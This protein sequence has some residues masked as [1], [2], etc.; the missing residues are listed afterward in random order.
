MKRFIKIISLILVVVFIS[1][2]LVGCSGKKDP[3]A[4][5][6]KVPVGGDGKFTIP[7]RIIS[8]ETIYEEG[9]FQYALY[10]DGTAIIYKHTG[11]EA[12][13]VIPDLL[14]GYPVVA[15]ASAA[16]YGNMNATSVT[17]GKNLE[18]IGSDAFNGCPQLAKVEIPESVWAIYPNAF[19]DTPWYDSL[20]EEE[21]VIVGD[22]VLLRYNGTDTTVV[23]P[24]TVKHTSS[25]FM[26]NETIKDITFPDSVYTIGAATLSSSNV[27]RVHLGNNVILIDDSAFAYCYE[28]R[29]IN[30]PD[31][32]KRIG[33]YAFASCAS[34]NYVNIGKNVETIGS[35]SFFRSTRFSYIYL[36]KSVKSIGTLA[37]E[38]CD[39]LSRVYYEGTEEEFNAIG[40]NGENSKLTDA[41]K[42]YNYNYSAGT[43]NSGSQGE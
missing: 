27:S 41:K 8:D 1:S 42:I 28:L 29:Y 26:G 36:P 7:E 32:L 10:D 37:F 21:F 4:S 39:Y 5:P 30:M 2:L 3:N 14:G 20:T 18:V 25:V 19:I 9:V 24:D 22:S 13:I 23:I 15:I 43:K 34:L 38:D 35:Y 40:L 6:N 12:E 16:F 31:S 11:D 33:D 17:M